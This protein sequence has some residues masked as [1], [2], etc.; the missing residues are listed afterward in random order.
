MR[1]YTNDYIFRVEKFLGKTVIILLQCLTL[2]SWYVVSS[3]HDSAI[4]VVQINFG[5]K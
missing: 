3:Y 2:P 5:C 4:L 1:S